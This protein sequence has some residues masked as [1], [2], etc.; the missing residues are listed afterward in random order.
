[1][2]KTSG[3]ETMVEKRVFQILAV[4]SLII[5]VIGVWMAFWNIWFILSAIFSLISGYAWSQ[6]GEI[7][8]AV[9]YLESEVSKLK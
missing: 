8:D 1:L 4:V 3:G 9:G 2:K 5:G 7:C 6:V